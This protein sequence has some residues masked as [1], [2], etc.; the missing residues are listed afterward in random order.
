MARQLPIGAKTGKVWGW[1]KPILQTQT[2]E[3][4]HLSVKAGWRCSDHYHGHKHNRFY[5]VAGRLKVVTQKA[6]LA[7]EVVLGPGEMT[8]VLPGD[9]HRFEAETDCELVELYWVTLDPDD[10]V[11]RTQGGPVD[12][13]APR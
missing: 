11:R 10:I 3:V 7:D 4:Q 2:V 6:G 9:E 13:D 12:P 5:V 1:T 8:D